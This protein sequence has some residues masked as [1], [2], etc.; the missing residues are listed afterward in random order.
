MTDQ[1]FNQIY[2]MMELSFPKTEFRGYAAQR[3]LLSRS[4]YRMLVER[5]EQQ[6]V[7]GFLAGWEFD[8][9]RYV[10]HIAVSPTLR[11][12][13]VGKRLMQRFMAE[14]ELPVILEVECPEGEEQRRRIGFYERLGFKLEDYAY[15]QPSL[16]AGE[17][18]VPLR[19]MSYPQALTPSVFNE[20]KRT[21][22]AEVYQ[23]PL[24]TATN[25]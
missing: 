20:M 3:S 18:A 12:G 17:P 1:V 8:Q 25:L 10:E 4:R 19:I 13:G 5:N 11:G 7:I 2:Q 9:F 22:Y 16:R 21:L 6:E 15:V 24:A 14:S 23:V